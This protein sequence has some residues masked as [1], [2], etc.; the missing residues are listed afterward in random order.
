MMYAAET[1]LGEPGGVSPL[2]WA[3][4]LHSCW[5]PIAS[6]EIA[7]NRQSDCN[8]GVDREHVLQSGGGVLR[9]DVGRR[10]RRQVA[11]SQKKVD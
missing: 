3:H 1:V 4:F 5:S 11:F 9:R 2:S 7:G 6:G 8:L 10:Q